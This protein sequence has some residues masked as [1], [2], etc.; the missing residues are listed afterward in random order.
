[1]SDDLSWMFQDTQLETS[2]NI[3]EPMIHRRKIRHRDLSELKKEKIE[4]FLT[5]LPKPGESFHIVSNG[6]FDYFNFMPVTVKLAGSLQAFYGSTWTMNRNNVVDMFK[7]FDEGKIKR[8]AI[9]TGTYFKHRE[10]SVANTLI[11][12]LSARKQRFIAFENHAKVMLMNDD[13]NFYVMEGSANFTANPRLEQNILVNDR[14]LYEFHRGWM[15][16]ILAGGGD[17]K[18]K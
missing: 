11:E 10:S 7:L 16:R 13:P 18:T 8:L 3:D 2:D 12:G 15:E 17:G 1:M 9:L 14:D 4:A 5:E 6:S